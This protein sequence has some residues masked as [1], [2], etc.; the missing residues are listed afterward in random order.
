MATSIGDLQIGWQYRAAC[1]GP[2]SQLFFAPSHLERKDA[3]SSSPAGPGDAGPQNAHGRQPA[4]DP[5]AREAGRQP[6]EPLTVI[7][8]C[9]AASA[10]TTRSRPA[11][12]AW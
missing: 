8:A 12:L 6:P 11:S 1:K 9:L 2:Q 10:T 4:R 3:A 7:P 5:A